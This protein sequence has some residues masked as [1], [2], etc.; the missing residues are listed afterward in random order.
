VLTINGIV[1][2]IELGI[3]DTHDEALASS[4]IDGFITVVEDTDKDIVA[5]WAHSD[6]GILM[7]RHGVLLLITPTI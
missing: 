6:E 7:F 4:D 3:P 5:D 2:A 1:N